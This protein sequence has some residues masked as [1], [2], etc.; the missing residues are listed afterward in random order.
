M[1]IRTQ[2]GARQDS[3]K[4]GDSLKRARFGRHVKKTP[5]DHH[6]T[7]SFGSVS[8]ALLVNIIRTYTENFFEHD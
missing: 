6:S 7:S 8:F 3:Y 4:P 2:S 5:K 1:L